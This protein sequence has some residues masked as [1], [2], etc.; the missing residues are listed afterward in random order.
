MNT[1]KAQPAANETPAVI[2]YLQPGENLTNHVITRLGEMVT[3]GELK[4][5]KNYAAEHAVRSAWFA[6]QDVKSR[7]EVPALQ[8]CTK[9]SIANAMLKMVRRGLNV[10]KS[11]GYFIVYGSTLQWQD[12]YLGTIAIALRE[13]V[14]QEVSAQ[15]IYEGDEFAYETRNGRKYITVHNQAFENINNDKLK[16]A[17]CIVTPPNGG[18]PFAEVMTMQQIRLAWMQGPMKGNSKAHNNFPDQMAMKTVIQ[19]GL[20]QIIKT[21]DDSSLFEDEVLDVPYQEVKNKIAGDANKTAIGFKE[22]EPA[23]VDTI[24]EPVAQSATAGQAEQEMTALPEFMK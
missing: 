14:A 12:S 11:Q 22:P 5:P 2:E 3:T 23:V 7:D 4:L 1:T 20:K 6:L 24:A 13:N 16:G 17:Y 18:E 8:C 10:D 15:P 21:T 9:H 19:R